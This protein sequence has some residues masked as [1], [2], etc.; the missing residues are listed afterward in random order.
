MESERGEEEEE[1]E[2]ADSD[3]EDK[4]RSVLVSLKGE[5]GGVIGAANRAMQKLEKVCPTG[6][7]DP[8]LGL[9]MIPVAQPVR[10]TVTVHAGAQPAAQVHAAVA[11][12]RP[13]A[14]SAAPKPAA[15]V[16]A[17]VRAISKSQ[18]S[19]AA[20]RGRSRKQTKAVSRLQMEQK[21]CVLAGAHHLDHSYNREHLGE[22]AYGWFRI[23][24]LVHKE[25]EDDK[26]IGYIK[27]APCGRLAKCIHKVIF[28]NDS[29]HPVYLNTGTRTK[30]QVNV[31]ED[32]ETATW[33]CTPRR[34]HTH[35]L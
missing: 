3:D 17:G 25:A 23:I 1:D 24:D 27:F 14:K 5:L 9:P 30:V 32:I 16:I 12:A 6:P 11:Q 22:Q 15:Q 10:L 26:T 34:A 18:R 29:T 31:R 21:L 2:V 7:G 19:Q 20:G 8:P 28:N 4:P 33:G 35:T 13:R